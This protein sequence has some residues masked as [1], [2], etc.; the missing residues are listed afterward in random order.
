MTVGAVY[1]FCRCHNEWLGAK[2]LQRQRE[3]DGVLC[4]EVPA[5][6]PPPRVT[7]PDAAVFACAACQNRHTPALEFRP[8]LPKK[9]RSPW[10]E[11]E[12]D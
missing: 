8:D 3:G 7:D 2:E 10:I 5:S 6:A 4:E 1:C 12:G 11:G 9:P